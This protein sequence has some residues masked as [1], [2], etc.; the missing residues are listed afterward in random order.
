MA[1]WEG[2][3]RGTVSGYKFFVTLIN[4]FGL[5][6]SYFF[7]RI[8]SYYYFLFDSKPRGIIQDFY[9]VHLGFPLKKAKRMTR[10]NFYLLGQTLIDKTAF[11]T[12]KADQ[13]EFSHIGHEHLVNLAEEKKGAILISAH[14]GN[15]DV[16][17]NLLKTTKLQAKINVVMYD[18]EHEKLKEYF[19]ASTGGMH[20]NVIPLKNDLSH[21]IS[22]HKAL[23]N[24]EFVCIHSDRFMGDAATVELDFLDSKAKFPIGP[25][26]I[27]SKFA[28]PVCFVYNVKNKKF[29]YQLSCSEPMRVKEN[30]EFFAKKFVSILEDMLKKYPEQWFNY[31]D[32][33]KT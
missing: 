8:V 2:K 25:F 18:G 27:A 22:I 20:F 14:V 28:A 3:S 17:G 12:G 23:S 33:F 10:K 7:L 1:E 31:F 11:L 4:V 15:W 5:P 29:G 26:Q 24:G 16:A 13:Y 21:I 32:F 30:P 6:T 19:D 9:H